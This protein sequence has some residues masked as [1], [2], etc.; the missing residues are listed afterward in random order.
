MASGV[1]AAIIALT[2]LAVV[3]AVSA[4][5]VIIRRKQRR[6]REGETE[7]K[8]AFSSTLEA[9]TP[10]LRMPNPWNQASSQ[11]GR[12]NSTDKPASNQDGDRVPIAPLPLR[13][14]R[15]GDIFNF[16]VVR[17]PTSVHPPGTR[18]TAFV[19]HQDVPT[20]LGPL[21]RIYRSASGFFRLDLGQE[22]TPRVDA[23]HRAVRKASHAGY[24]DLERQAPQLRVPIAETRREQRDP[25]V[26]PSSSTP[27]LTRNPFRGAR[28]HSPADPALE[29]LEETLAF[30][31]STPARSNSAPTE[32]WW[33][34]DLGNQ[35]PWN[36]VLS[37]VMR[38]SA[39]A[40]TRPESAG[41]QMRD[42]HAFHGNP[43]YQTSTLWDDNASSAKVQRDVRDGSANFCRARPL[44]TPPSEQ[45]SPRISVA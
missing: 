14:N 42:V 6:R 33:P 21:T 41:P 16:P 27:V 30:T 32:G 13:P 39:S 18:T 24:V 3:G 26:S 22:R 17:S 1:L 10:L 8:A 45:A 12:Q 35:S 11:A 38:S 28:D 23:A 43:N 19:R 40:A 36:N 31:P 29:E 5:I 9:E 15:P 7:E 44:P 20:H 34:N 4:A 25:S 37:A 2:I